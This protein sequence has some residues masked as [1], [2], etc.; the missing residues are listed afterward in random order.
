MDITISTSRPRRLKT[1]VNY[2]IPGEDEPIPEVL[3]I[4]KEKCPRKQGYTRRQK[5]VLKIEYHNPFNPEAAQA[6]LEK[7]RPKL[8]AER[9]EVNKYL[10]L[11][12]KLAKVKEKANEEAEEEAYQE[13]FKK[14][15]EVIRLQE[16]HMIENDLEEL[17]LEKGVKFLKLL[18]DGGR[19]DPKSDSYTINYRENAN[20]A[21]C[22]KIVKIP[23]PGWEM[24]SY[25]PEVIPNRILFAEEDEGPNSDFD[26][27]HASLKERDM[28][29]VVCAPFLPSLP[30]K[31]L[32]LI[33]TDTRSP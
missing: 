7:L 1:E 33:K 20:D 21:K 22:R 28:T 10:K 2:H 12:K 5:K 32:Q 29:M 16:K 25:P 13:R 6:V 27:V 17:G 31:V 9:Q 23:Q 14:E 24:P 8:K 11:Q 3:V 4:E 19:L 18:W 15:L 30:I 26:D